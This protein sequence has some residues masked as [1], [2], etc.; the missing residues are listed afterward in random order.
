MTRVY[1]CYDGVCDRMCDTVGTR[2]HPCYPDPDKPDSIAFMIVYTCD[3]CIDGVCICIL[4]SC[5]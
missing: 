4:Q 3:S 1:V 5:L 2:G